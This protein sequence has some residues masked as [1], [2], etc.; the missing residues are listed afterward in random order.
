MPLPY[1]PTETPWERVNFTLDRVSVPGGWLY[2]G[3]APRRYM[4]FVPEPPAWNNL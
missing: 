3:E 4:V 2:R 1:S